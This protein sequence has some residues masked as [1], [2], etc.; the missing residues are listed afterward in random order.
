MLDMIV[1]S[2]G[3]GQVLVWLLCPANP[4]RGAN[5]AGNGDSQMSGCVMQHCGQCLLHPGG[6]KP[7][8][9]RVAH[10][11]GTHDG[12]ELHRSVARTW[13]NRRGRRLVSR[14]QRMVG[15]EDG[16]YPTT[17]DAR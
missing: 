4:G 14:W 8:E 5:F 2:R 13:A 7:I 16:P 3:R 6:L 10:H 17:R 1:L 15:L 11:A 9:G 12:W